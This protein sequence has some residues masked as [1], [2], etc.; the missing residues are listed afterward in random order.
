MTTPAFKDVLQCIDG[1]HKGMLAQVMAV[2]NGRVDMFHRGSDGTPTFF[3]ITA[4]DATANWRHIGVARIGPSP[5]ALESEIATR[6]T[7]RPGDSSSLPIATP[8]PS[9]LA[10]LKID[11]LLAPIPEDMKVVP[12]NT[13]PEPLDWGE[14]AVEPPPTPAEVSLG[15]VN[16][17]ALVT[18]G[19]GDSAEVHYSLRQG[20]D[21]KRFT[22]IPI[23][24]ARRVIPQVK[25][26]SVTEIKEA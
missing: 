17:S 6:P 16:Y 5:K 18:N 3:K 25:P 1:P 10:P 12:L 19:A 7:S 4:N 13:E 21:P 23:L 8:A 26:F 15:K 11:E 22:G 9:T 14:D 20:V 2:N 24:K